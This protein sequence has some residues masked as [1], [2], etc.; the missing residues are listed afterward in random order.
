MTR[1]LT[2]AAA[3]LCIAVLPLAGCGGKKKGIPRADAAN[4]IALLK[5]ARRQAAANPPACNALATS[6][7]ALSTQ[8]QRLPS[9]VDSNVKDSLTNGIGNLQNLATKQC[10]Q[11]QT[12]TTQT[13]TTQT[14][15]TP[16]QTT[17]TQ[18]QTTPTQT[19][20]TPTPT[21]PTTPTTTTPPSGGTT[22]PGPP[23]P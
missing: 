21:T 8:V 1:R 23:T 16:T 7:Q 14:Q 9:D 11:T 13:T 10:S 20:T 19:T 5:D 2:V 15:T 6:I 3:C 22:V 12:T 18:T 4:L 17:P